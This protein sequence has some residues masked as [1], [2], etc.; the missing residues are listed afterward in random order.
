MHPHVGK[1]GP[2]ACEMLGRP[3][4]VS[5]Q[6]YLDP[7]LGKAWTWSKSIATTLWTLATRF[8]GHESQIN[9]TKSSIQET[10]IGARSLVAGSEASRRRGQSG[11]QGRLTEMPA[12]RMAAL[13]R[14]RTAE[15][16]NEKTTSARES[17]GRVPA[18]TTAIASQEPCRSFFSTWQ[19]WGLSAFVVRFGPSERISPLGQCFVG[20]WCGRESCRGYRSHCASYVSLGCTVSHVV[21]VQASR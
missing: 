2:V 14:P 9:R 10:S 13:T 20:M 11:R 16:R 6:S 19:A 15:N 18:E 3:G 7:N 8:L 12:S 5:P 21:L 17:P 4:R 1:A